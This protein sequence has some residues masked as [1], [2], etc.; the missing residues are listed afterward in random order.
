MVAILYE[1]GNP[2]AAIRLEQLWND[3]ARTRAF[4]LSCG[5][6]L[7][8]FSRTADGVDVAKICAEHSP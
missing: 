4:H 7:D 5:W 1:N 3:V 8:F 2:E 6:P